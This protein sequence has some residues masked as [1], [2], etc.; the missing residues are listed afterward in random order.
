MY[1]YILTAILAALAGTTVYDVLMTEKGLKAG[2]AVEGNTWLVGSKPT[3][4]TL[5]LRDSL[6]AVLATAP[7]IV[8]YAMGSTAG[9][10]GLLIMPVV[11]AVKHVL[12]GRQW[13]KLLAG[14]KLSTAPESAWKKFLDF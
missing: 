1:F 2:V 13:A 14:G 9:A 10:Y 7:S 6:T 4:I 3:A 11:Y 5:Y 8:T 12:G